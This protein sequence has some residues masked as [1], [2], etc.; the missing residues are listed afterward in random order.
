MLRPTLCIPIKTTANFLLLLAA[1][2]A[3]SFFTSSG[4][5]EESTGK[6]PAVAEA[7]APAALRAQR[8]AAFPA[9]TM[10]SQQTFTPNGSG[11]AQIVATRHRSQRSD[12]I[13]KV[14]VTRLRPDG[15]TNQVETFIGVLGVGT[16][17]LDER[18]GR[19]VYTATML[20]ELPED[21]AGALRSDPQFEREES[22]A[23]HKAVVLR[24]RGPGGKG[25][26]EVFRVPDL[27]G[28]VVKTVRV[29]PAGREVIEPTSLVM[30]EPAGL[31]ILAELVAYPAD[32]TRYERHIREMEGRGHTE[33]ARV[34]RRQLQRMRRLKP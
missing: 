31:D 26:T 16:F 4:R 10:I 1:L 14:V 34:L 33:A 13:F 12:G 22:V 23:G 5:T 29:S 21:L 28:L 3:L 15:S 11:T 32:Y 6:P 8:P 19:L 27:M 30:G 9:Y 24:R 25:Y 2:I 17:F 18:Q 7:A 20:D